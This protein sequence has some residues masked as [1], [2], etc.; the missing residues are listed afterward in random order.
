MCGGYSLS[1]EDMEDIHDAERAE[2]NDNHKEQE[3]QR[4]KDSLNERV[5][6]D[7]P[8]PTPPTPR[9][10][11][12]YQEWDGPRTAPGYRAATVR[13]LAALAAI[14]VADTMSAHVVREVV[15][16]LG[17]RL[18]AVEAALG[19]ESPE[20][21]ANIMALALDATDARRNADRAEAYLELHTGAVAGPERF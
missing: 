14:T 18:M 6:T 11:Y 19:I 13:E 9:S 4:V 8:A 21:P 16:N 3:Y 17:Q 15:K 10:P 1:V 12:G 7:G 2:S 5:F 20:V